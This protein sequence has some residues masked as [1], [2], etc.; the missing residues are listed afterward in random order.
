MAITHH[1]PTVNFK[2]VMT[3]E[4]FKKWLATFDTNKDG[5]ISKEELRHAI[6]ATGAWFPWLKANK[7]VH[8]ADTN[9]DG[10]ID[11]NEMNNLVDYAEKH[12]N[13]KIA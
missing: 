5:R 10:F 4:E 3:K 9:G 12:L 6:R 11:E 2:G 1:A 7:A 8:A 13:V